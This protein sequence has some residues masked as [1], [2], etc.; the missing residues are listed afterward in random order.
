MTDAPGGATTSMTRSVAGMGAAAA[1]S[2]AFGGIRMVV[3]AAVLGTT[4]LGNTFQASNSLSNVLFELLAAGALSAV[5]VPTF[6]DLLTRNEGR[7]LEEVAGGL[8]SIAL[9]GLGAVT[10][11]GVLLAP[12]IAR[13]L[14]AGVADGAI[15]ADQRELATYLL[16]FFIPQ[17]LLYAVGAVAT[18]LLHARGMFAVTAAA[19][20][21]NTVVLVAAMAIFHAMAGGGAGLHLSSGARLCLAVGGTLGVAAFVGVPVIALRRTGFR[22]RLGLRRALEDGDVTRLLRLSGWAVLQHSG[23]GILLIAAIVASGGVAGGVVAYQLAMVVFLAPY[24]ILSQPIHTAVLP[25]LAADRA[26]GDEA[27]LRRSLRWASDAMAVVT[28]PVAAALLALSVPVMQV[29]AFGEAGEG[30][31]PELL[32]AAL[33]GLAVGVPVYGG[34]LLMTRVAYALDD[35][36]TPAIASLGSALLGAAGMV[37]VGAT[38][39]GTGRL[40]AIG[41][42]HSAAYLLGL[43]WLA[44]RVRR[45]V[46]GV[47]GLG[48]LRALV[49]ASAT[50]LAMWA[51]IRAWSPDGR[52]TT[53][54][55]VLVV[56]AGGAALYLLALRRLGGLPGR[57]PASYRPPG[58]TA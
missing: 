18:A 35:S 36:R 31:S 33:A 5:L 46:G 30:D 1:V 17:V 4:Y 37:V 44:A 3:I 12:Q 11:A 48:Q 47:V 29:L 39:D 23:T 54:T 49:L 15:A 38:V 50:G 41:G 53:L 55:A 24:G 6:V 19:P 20:I 52:V 10:V 13:L 25:R 16:R 43:V 2:R 28:L 8:L 58:S 7:R 40:A 45:A 27:G 32:G 22:W 42:A 9:A 56:S 21:G 14:T 34:F 57:A 26:A 51:A